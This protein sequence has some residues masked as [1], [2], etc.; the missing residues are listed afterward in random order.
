MAR[1]SPVFREKKVHLNYCAFLEFSNKIESS[2]C[3]LNKVGFFQLFWN[4]G[5][6]KVKTDKGFFI[7]I[8]TISIRESSPVKIVIKSYYYPR[9]LLLDSINSLEKCSSIA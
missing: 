7:N 3:L 9:L 5:P 4:L 6:S 8:S 2:F 1:I